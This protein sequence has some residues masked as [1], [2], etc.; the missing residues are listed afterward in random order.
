MRFQGRTVCMMLVGLVALFVLADT[1]A[2][3]GAGKGFRIIRGEGSVCAAGNGLVQFHGTAS[4]V[5]QVR[6]GQLIISDESA[7]VEIRGKGIKH[8]LPNGWVLY[9]GFNGS[10]HLEGE[11][12]FGQLMGKGVRMRAEGRGIIMLMGRGLYRSPCEGSEAQWGFIN[13]EGVAVELGEYVVDSEEL[14]E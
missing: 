8:T 3:D 9:Q 12:L 10:V 14:A 5:A 2:A 1:D 13:Q 4:L 11:N 7:V 6:K